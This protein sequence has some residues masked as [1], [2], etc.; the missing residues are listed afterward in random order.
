M[1]AKD[2]ICA[3]MAFMFSERNDPKKPSSSIS[4]SS[5]S[6]SPY[7]PSP[8]DYPVG[9]SRAI[10]DALVARDPAE[11]RARLDQHYDGIT[12]LLARNRAAAA[13]NQT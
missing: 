6:S 3:E 7:V 5:S 10:V 11:A 8:F 4:S 13:E 9:G 2:T 1:P 12:R